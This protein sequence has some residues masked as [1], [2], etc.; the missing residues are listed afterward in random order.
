MMASQDDELLDAFVLR[1]NLGPEASE[2]LKSVPQE[3]RSKVVRS[4]DPRGTKDGNVFGRLQAFARSMLQPANERQGQG[5][6][7]AAHAPAVETASFNEPPAPVPAQTALAVVPGQDSSDYGWSIGLDENGVRLFGMLPPDLRETLISDFDPRGT[8]D[9]NVLG[10][11]FGFARVVWAQRLGLD[12]VQKQEAATLLRSLSEEA[13]ARVMGQFD[14]SGTKDGNILARLQ[15]FAADVASRFAPGGGKG[16]IQAYTPPP[17]YSPPPVYSPPPAYSPAPARAAPAVAHAYSPSFAEFVSRMGLDAASANFLQS[18]PEEVSSVVLNS[19]NPSGTKDGNVWGRLFGFV[20][21]VWTQ[22][23]GLDASM[24]NFLKSLPEETQKVVMVK[25][26]PSRTKDGNIAARLESFARSVASNPHPLPIA[27]QAYSQPAHPPAVTQSYGGQQGYAGSGQQGYAGGA[28]QGYA[29]GAQQGYAGGQQ[30]YAG[31]QQ[32]YAGGQQGYT[33]GALGGGAAGMREFSQRWGLNAQAAAFLK[34]L[35]ETVSSVIIS[36]FNANGTKDGNVWGRLFGFVRSVWS[37]KL[38]LDHGAF[39]YV[40]GLPEE[41]QMELMTR[42]PP[43]Q[44]PG[45]ELLPQLQTVADEIRRGGVPAA[46]PA[47]QNASTAALTE[48]LEAFAQR[49]GL[50]AE[51]VE[52]MRALS[53]EVQAAVVSDFDPAGTKDGNVFG[54][55]QNFARAVENRR[56]RMQGEAHGRNVRQRWNEA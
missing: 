43:G 6:H 35:P 4:F 13:Q 15:R 29:G 54:R 27:K 56:K 18:L 49:C 46:Q 41:V 31:G 32:G 24:V 3:V 51:A 1:L 33:D 52:F 25:F 38:G 48:S 11:L 10:R 17:A 23:L 36:S 5:Y 14:V 50:D 9:G 21:S 37:Q 44:A 7:V 40:R 39:N 55:L 34:A 26:D 45:N 28:Q 53:E 47:L 12:P 16:A 42:F 2:F 19:F 30:G 22:R 8:K 20:R